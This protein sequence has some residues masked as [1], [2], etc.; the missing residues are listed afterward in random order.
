MLMLIKTE[1]HSFVLKHKTIFTVCRQCIRLSEQLY[2][3]NLVTQK[4]KI[5]PTEV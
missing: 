1:T 4:A 5:I 3:I 2:Y